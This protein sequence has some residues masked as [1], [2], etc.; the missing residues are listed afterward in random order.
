MGFLVVGSGYSGPGSLFVFHLIEMEGCIAHSGKTIF[1]NN[2]L[3]FWHRW[4][5]RDPRD[6]SS[7]PEL[8][9]SQR[10]K[11]PHRTNEWKVILTIQSEFM[12]VLVTLSK[13]NRDFIYNHHFS[14]RFEFTSS[15]SMC[16]LQSRKQLV[17]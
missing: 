5:P 15:V 9:L 4:T 2:E 16:T 17:I 6:L 13:R 14:L 1:Q 12:R 7:P 3:Y 8:F 10:R 11:E